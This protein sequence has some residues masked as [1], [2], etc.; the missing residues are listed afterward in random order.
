MRKESDIQ[1]ISDLILKRMRQEITEEESQFLDHWLGLSVKN[2]ELYNRLQNERYVLEQYRLRQ[3]IDTNKAWKQVISSRRS[4][5]RYIGYAAAILLLLGSTF[6]YWLESQKEIKVEETTAMSPIR[7]GGGK[8]TLIVSNQQ[9][10]QL[11]KDCQLE[12][13]DN[14]GTKYRNDSATLY[15]QTATQADTIAQTGNTH[16]LVIGRGGEYCVKLSDGTKVHLNSDSK[17]RYPV[18]FTASERRVYLEGEAYFEVSRDTEHPFIVEGK[19][20]SVQVLGTS[21]NISN[22]KDD[23]VSRVVLLEG[24]V[25]VQKANKKYKLEPNEALE[26][27][28]D[29]ISIKQVNAANAISW[30]NDKFYFS[31]E[32]LEVV[33][34]RLARWYDVNLFYANQT[35][36]DYHFTGFIPKYA[37]IV[38]AFQILELTADVK[39]EVKDRTVTIMRK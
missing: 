29:Q 25:Q 30:K 16:T 7:P 3:T 28:G 21:F 5:T 24:K 34:T 9:E 11:H 27:D 8:A 26:I 37:D 23:D 19:D 22:Y 33:M 32:R 18:I 35:I 1:K 10:I 14:S 36:K 2:Q 6:V 12:L 31:N 17:L 4:L 13:T 15:Y 38:K 39:F 20:F